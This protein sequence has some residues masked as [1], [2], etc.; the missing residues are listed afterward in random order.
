MMRRVR[1]RT[2]TAEDMELVAE[3]GRGNA[4][5]KNGYPKPSIVW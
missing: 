2:P 1:Q 4:V 3:D 5:K